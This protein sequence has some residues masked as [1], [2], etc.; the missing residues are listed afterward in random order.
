[1]G[2]ETGTSVSID[3]LVRLAQASE[4][5]DTWAMAQLIRKLR[6]LAR[7]LAGGG[8]GAFGIADD[9]ENAAYDGLV[10]AVRRH[11][12]S[13]PG[14]L[15][16]ALAYMSG[17]VYRE[18]RRL[19]RMMQ[20][21]DSDPSRTVGADAVALA[22]LEPWGDGRLAAAVADLSPEQRQLI[23]RRYIDDASLRTIAVEAGVSVSAIS[24]RLDT[25]H[26]ACERRLAA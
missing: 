16:L 23:E 3:G 4:S 7:K 24:Q 17:A 6:P 22:R 19:L 12:A 25:A 9:L 15:A 26:R 18:R 20:E 2:S 13:R 8:E 21:A 10:Q 5:D 1:M 11:D 14:F